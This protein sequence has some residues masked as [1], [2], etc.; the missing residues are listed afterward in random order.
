MKFFHYG[1]VV[2]SFDEMVSALTAHDLPKP[3]RSTVPLLCYWQDYAVHLPQ[4]MGMLDLAVN[5]AGTTLSFEHRVPSLNPRATPSH[6]DLMIESDHSAVAIEGKWTEPLYQTIDK[7]IEQGKYPDSRRRV[8]THWLEMLKP[9]ST[10]SLSPESLPGNAIV[11]QLLHR[12]ASA[13]YAAGGDKQAVVLYQVFSDGH[14]EHPD[15]MKMF[16][17]LA[18]YLQP[19]E[20][21]RFAVLESRM[22]PTVAFEALLR[23]VEDAGQ[24]NQAAGLIRQAILDRELFR[25]TRDTLSWFT[26]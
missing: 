21:L 6:T 20:R 11:Y 13:C 2:A 14:H 10:R 9:F 5:E 3:T 1:N 12:T 25:F 19:N 15:Y 4:L 8:A 18:N 7:W 22:E 26:P 23:H 24:K 16:K 17:P